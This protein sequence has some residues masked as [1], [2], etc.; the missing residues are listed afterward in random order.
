MLKACNFQYTT[1][2]TFINIGELRTCHNSIKQSKLLLNCLEINK[3]Y[4]KNK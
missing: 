3:N 4:V 1:K 2:N